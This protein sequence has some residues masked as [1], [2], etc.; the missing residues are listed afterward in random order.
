MSQLKLIKVKRKL[1]SEKNLCI[2]KRE[3]LLHSFIC[4]PAFQ[5]G[6]GGSVTQ[7]DPPKSYWATA[8]PAGG[9]GATYVVPSGLKALELVGR[10]WKHPETGILHAFQHYHW[11]NW[12]FQIDTMNQVS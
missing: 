8:H 7:F 3:C 11:E 2:L 1:S 4:L 6:I 12:I 10:T 5:I 9:G